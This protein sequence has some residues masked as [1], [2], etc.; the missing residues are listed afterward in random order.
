MARKKTAFEQFFSLNWHRKRLGGAK[1]VKSSGDFAAMKVTLV[2]GDAPKQ[3]RGSAKSL[4]EHLENLRKEFAGQP[5]LLWHHAKL[6]VLLR[7]GVDTETV[8][9]QFS[10]LWDA[11]GLYLCEA[12]NLRWLV[13]A[14]DTFAD[15]A[16]DSETRVL[17]TLVSLLVNT[18]KIY[19]TE[20]ILADGEPL[21]LSPAKVARVQNELIPLFSGLS[22]FTI[23]TD[24]TL[25]NTRWRLDPLME[26]GAVGLILKTVFDR[27]QV[28]DTAFAR[29]RAVHHRER[30]GWWSS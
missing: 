23:G 14:T 2:D 22:C 11:E 8:F 13:S 30:T 18:V 21:P 1:H 12:L 20:R 19:E 28:E 25:R 15:H 10:E 6:I 3:T 5:E 27:L 29:L 26:K 4:D 9:A 16:S 17:A 24:D 7:R